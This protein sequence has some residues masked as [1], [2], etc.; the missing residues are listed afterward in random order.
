MIECLLKRLQVITM[1]RCEA[2]CWLYGMSEL[3]CLYTS[4]L[5]FFYSQHFSFSSSPLYYINLSLRIFPL[6]FCSHYL[7]DSIF[8]GYL[9][10]T[11]SMSHPIMFLPQLI[12]RSFSVELL[13]KKFRSSGDEKVLACSHIKTEVR[14]RAFIWM[15]VPWDNTAL[16]N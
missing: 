3:S 10:S 13:K 9:V 8:E 7:T 11:V 4:I 15:S 16:F 2:I 1:F 6:K 5:F 14:S 12:I